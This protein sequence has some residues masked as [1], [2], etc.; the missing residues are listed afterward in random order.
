MMGDLENR[1]GRFYIS[2]HM[3]EKDPVSVFKV[4]G[5][6]LVV[7]AEMDYATDTVH[8]TALSYHFEKVSR[9]EKVPLYKWIL[10]SVDEHEPKAVLVE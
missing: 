9:G 7:R 1:F 8:Y 5:Q 6:C 2:R 10:S 4:L 3:I